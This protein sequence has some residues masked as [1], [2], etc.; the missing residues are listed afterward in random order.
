[1]S[2]DPRA[3][4]DP[5]AS[6]APGVSVGAYTIIGAEVEIGAGTVVGSHV[7]IKGPTVIGKEN[8]FY[9]FS[10]IGDDPQDKKYG[11]EQTRLEIGDRN[12]VREYCTINRGT[13][14]GGGV[15]H[16]G[17]DNWI[18]AYVHIAHDCLIANN[19]VFAN[20]ASLAGHVKVD[21]FAVLGG[22]TLVHQFCS[23]G[24]HSFSGMGSTLSKDLP[25]YVMASGNPATPRGLN[26]E[27]LKRRGFSAEAI[28][29][30]RRAYKILFRSGLTLEEAIKKLKILQQDHK[31][32]G[33]LVSFLENSQRSILR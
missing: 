9:S 25:P 15:T 19:T 32:V 24:A 26:S 6:L 4:V 16:I 13:E 33:V 11:G 29:V 27:G 18:M 10:S 5:S 3:V 7:V 23:I 30:L 20:N 22:F 2:I 8:R 12:V 14:Q 17:D 1:M 21:D 28:R 31:E